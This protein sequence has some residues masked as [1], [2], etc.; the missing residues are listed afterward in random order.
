MKKRIVALAMVGLV[1]A[2][3]M[4]GCGKVQTDNQKSAETSAEGTTSGE[5]AFGTM[6][7]DGMTFA[8]FFSNAVTFT[9][10]YHS[11]KAKI[12]FTKV[13]ADVTTKKLTGAEFTLY[14][15]HA[16]TTPFTR[17]GSTEAVT[18]ISNDAGFV[19]VTDLPYNTETGTTYYIKETTAPAGYVTNGTI[20]AAT[21][22]ADGTVSMTGDGN[23]DK[24]TIIKNKEIETELTFYK[25][26]KTKNGT[27]ITLDGAVFEI[28]RLEGSEYKQV[29]D[30]TGVDS[31]SRFTIQ[32]AAGIKL[33]RIK[34]GTYQLTEITAPAGY[35]LLADPISFVIENGQLKNP[36]NVP[37]VVTFDS[38]AKNVTIYN[39][40]GIELP[41][42]GGMGTLMTT[43]SGMALM[44]IAL[45]YLILVKRREKG[46]LN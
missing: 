16:A 25:K 23:V 8:E 24:M 39:T 13:D 1:A 34:D 42:T 5:I 44:L 19:E 28:K 10:E 46:G 15:D 36:E 18:A 26:S 33:T 37:D 38:T 17:E 12:Q 31:K 45:G 40:A 41:E 21:I 14:T 3:A 43:M 29:T 35:N 6:G 32:T 30:I 2:T 27:E 20:Y 4:V 22:A 9:N 11:R 7:T